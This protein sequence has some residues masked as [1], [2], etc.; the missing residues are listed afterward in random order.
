MRTQIV[1][2]KGDPQFA[3]PGWHSGAS[4]RLAIISLMIYLFCIGLMLLGK[5]VRERWI[6]PPREGYRAAI[7]DIV[8]IRY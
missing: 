3:V 6:L 2:W 1:I 5:S 8:D 4:V 7:K